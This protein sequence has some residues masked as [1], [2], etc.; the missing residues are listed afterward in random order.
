MR[1]SHLSGKTGTL[2]HFPVPVKGTQGIRGTADDYRHGGM[3]AGPET[4]SDERGMM[5]DE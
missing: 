4:L 3:M 1:D 2:P 5:N